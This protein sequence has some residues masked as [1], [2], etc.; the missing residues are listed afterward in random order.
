MTFLIISAASGQDRTWS[1]A[2][3]VPLAPGP[4]SRQAQVART[5]PTPSLP[6][7]AVLHPAGF[8]R[9]QA[10]LGLRGQA[11]VERQLTGI[12]SDGLSLQ[13]IKLSSGGNVPRSRAEAPGLAAQSDAH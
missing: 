8:L 13:I 4:H 2:C 10:S 3:R 11:S 12:Q 7:A 6:S 1:W 5:G 9:C